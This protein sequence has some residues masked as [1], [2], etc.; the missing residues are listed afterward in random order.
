MRITVWIVM[1]ASLLMP[2]WL[3]SAS[4]GA[5]VGADLRVVGSSGQLDDITQY[6]DTTTMPT[7]APAR[8]VAAVLLPTPPFGLAIKTILGSV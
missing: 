3:G 4:A 7:S 1:L 2:A 8:L 5:S 6:S